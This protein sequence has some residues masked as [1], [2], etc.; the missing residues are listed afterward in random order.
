LSGLDHTVWS[1]PKSVA[2]DIIADSGDP[3]IAWDGTDHV[4]TYWQESENPSLA[5][6]NIELWATYL[7][8]EPAFPTSGLDY[9]GFAVMA[10]DSRY[11]QPAVA[12]RP[13]D[14]RCVIPY[15]RFHEASTAYPMGG[16]DR[17]RYRSIIP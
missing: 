4:I 12:C 7:E 1:A 13:S 5:P 16:T 2:A 11:R 3:A 15:E 14:E 17:V 8:Y 9:D 6:F 10:T